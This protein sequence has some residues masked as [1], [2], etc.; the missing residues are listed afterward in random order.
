MNRQQDVLHEVFDF[1]GSRKAALAAHDP[2]D[3]GNDGFEKLCIRGGVACL[4]PSH[5][6]R[7]LLVGHRLIGRWLVEHNASVTFPALPSNPNTTAQSAANVVAEG[8][9]EG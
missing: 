8:G 5:E 9:P 2:P 6:L 1:V 7:E 4:R 3:S